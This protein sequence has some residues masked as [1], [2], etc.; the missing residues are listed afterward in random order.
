MAYS[1]EESSREVLFELV[2]YY[3]DGFVANRKTDSQTLHAEESHWPYV[4]S[5]WVGLSPEAMAVGR[6]SVIVYA[7]GDKLVE[8]DYL[9]T[10]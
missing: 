4:R 5:W 10:P 8:P 1:L 2:D 7:N 9:L 3:E 6:Y